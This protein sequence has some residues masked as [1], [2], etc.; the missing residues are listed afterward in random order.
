L[1]YLINNNKFSTE[2]RKESAFVLN[3]LIREPLYSFS[4]SSIVYFEKTIFSELNV[5]PNMN[6]EL[7][8]ILNS[9]I[10]YRAYNHWP[11]FI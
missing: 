1:V 10:K 9:Y 5:D 6:I 2:I 4:N 8:S 7:K 3:L 11:D